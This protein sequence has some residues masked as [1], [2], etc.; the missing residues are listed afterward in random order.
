MST[1]REWHSALASA[2]ENGY[3]V[4]R[5]GLASY[6]GRAAT[7]LRLAQAATSTD[8]DQKL[9]Q[10]VANAYQKMKQ[11]SDKYVADKGNMN[12]I[13][14]NSL[15]ND[16]IDQNLVACGKTLGAMAAGGQFTDDSACH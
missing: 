14:P 16:P 7:T 9:A 11:L 2:I 4:T 6:Q 12:Y 1:L 8:A 10:L 5:E 15:Q 3:P 13:D